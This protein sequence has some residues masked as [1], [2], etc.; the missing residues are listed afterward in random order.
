MSD[1]LIDWMREW[2]IGWLIDWLVIFS[3]TEWI[4]YF[5]REC[6]IG[7]AALQTRYEEGKARFQEAKQKY[8]ENNPRE[9][10]KPPRRLTQHQQTRRRGGFK[11]DLHI[12]PIDCPTLPASP[13]ELFRKEDEDRSSDDWEVL[14][15]DQRLPYLQAALKD[16]ARYKVLIWKVWKIFYVYRTFLTFP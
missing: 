12:E 6:L 4:G 11:V 5:E 1:W 7:Q 13:S 16:E 10:V 9:C 8:Y 15:K 2:V 3:I 14:S